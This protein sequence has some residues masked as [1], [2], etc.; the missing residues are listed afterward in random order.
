M[1]RPFRGFF[2]PGKERMNYNTISLDVFPCSNK[3]YFKKNAPFSS[4]KNVDFARIVHYAVEA[5]AK[6]V[7]VHDPLSECSECVSLAPRSPVV[8]NDPEETYLQRQFRK[9]LS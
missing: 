9:Q 2:F 6:G 3:E 8:C 7:L 5:C 1:K 4:R